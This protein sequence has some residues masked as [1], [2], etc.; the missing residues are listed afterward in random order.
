MTRRPYTGWDGNAAGKRAGVETFVALTVKH[1][2]G[3]VW[4]LGTWGVRNQR[5]PGRAKPSVH[6]TGRA[7]DMS[8]RR[9]P[10][11]YRRSTR[12]FADYRLA[13]Q[14]AEFWV[15]N[16]DL[17]LIEEI[18]DYYPSP[19]GRGWRCNRSAW[20]TYRKQTIGSSP[21]GDFFHV[22]IAPTYAD[23]SAYYERA[24]ADVDNSSGSASVP[25]AAPTDSVA[26]RAALVA[27]PGDPELTRA[28]ERVSK[29]SV[30]TLQQILIAHGWAVFTR[31]DGRYGDKTWRSVKAM[32]VKLGFLR[33]QVDGRYGPKTAKRLTTHLTTRG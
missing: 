19:F 12:G 5:R 7:A 3:G 24:F 20:K 22:E 4:N 29:P 2:D 15:A 17:F 27:P 1:F 25:D 18:H 8:W 10:K 13:L 14:V 23:D 31:V 33:K 30:K 26:A 11:N 6:G 28:D 16:A 32:Q 9:D 21:G